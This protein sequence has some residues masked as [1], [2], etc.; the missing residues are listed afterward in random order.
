MTPLDVAI[1][2]VVIDK[3]FGCVLLL[4]SRYVG[5]VAVCVLVPIC[6]AR[7]GCLVV[8]C[9]LFSLALIRIRMLLVTRRIV[10]GVNCLGFC[11]C[12]ISSDILL[13]LL[14]FGV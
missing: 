12:L 3:F 2:L 5:C 1:T 8:R 14:M 11:S 10:G 9:V 7:L 6:F 4:F 13:Y